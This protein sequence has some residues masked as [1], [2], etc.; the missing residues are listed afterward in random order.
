L[1]RCASGRDAVLPWNPVT[2][3]SGI[4]FYE[5]TLLVNVGGSDLNVVATWQVESFNALNVSDQTDCGRTFGWQV[6]ARDNT[7]H[8][9]QRDSAVFGIDLP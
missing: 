9:G 3:S 5:V 6:R 7:G 2:D 1:S 4:D 8:W